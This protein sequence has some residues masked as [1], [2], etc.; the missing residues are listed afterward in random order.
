MSR[1]LTQDVTRHLVQSLI[2]SRIDYCNVAFAGL[3]QR[4]IIR[5]QAVINAAARLVLRLKKFDHISNAIRDQLQW[6]RIGDRINFK[7]CIL[8]YKCLN[9]CAPAYLADNIKPLADDPRRSRLRSSKTADVFIPATKTKM[10][11]RAFRVAGPRA[12]NSLPSTLQGIKTEATFKKQLKLHLLS[13][14]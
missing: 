8:M 10:G 13:S 9:N 4:S 12:W 3:P 5:L 1:S 2:L 6:L 7:L 14:S 11:D